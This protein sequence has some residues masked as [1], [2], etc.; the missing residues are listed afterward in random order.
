MVG[1]PRQRLRIQPT[2]G[3]PAEIHITATAGEHGAN[4]ARWHGLGQRA[5]VIGR[6]QG[7]R[8]QTKRLA[9]TGDQ[10]QVGPGHTEKFGPERSYPV[11]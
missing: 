7:A 9:V 6:D 11:V 4:Q 3:Q 10:Q 2:V 1:D 8:D 5:R